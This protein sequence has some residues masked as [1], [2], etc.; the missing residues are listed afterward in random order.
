MRIGESLFRGLT[1]FAI[2]GALVVGI[3]VVT[4]LDNVIAFFKQPRIWVV[5]LA[6]LYGYVVIDE[7]TN[8]KKD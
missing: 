5:G 6:V 4:G 1:V 8:N 7:T 2:L 3:L